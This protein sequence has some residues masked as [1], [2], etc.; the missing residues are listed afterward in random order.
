MTLF[1]FE[2]VTKR[3]PDGRH[4]LTVFE[5]VSFEIDAGDFVGLWGTRRSGKSTLLRIAAGIDVPDT[6]RVL[7]DGQD[8][9][10]LSGDQRA[11]LLRTRG[12]GLVSS[13][14]RPTVSQEVIDD[15]AVAL[16]SDSYSLRQARRIA[17]EHLEQMGALK[18]AHMRTETLSIGEAMRV[19][20]AR[21]LIREPRLLLVDEPAALPSPS[22]RQE[23]Y[24]LL[25]SLGRSR[26]LAVLIASEDL[27][28]IRRARRKMTIGAGAVR[29]MDKKGEVVSFPLGRVSD[30]RSG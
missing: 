19:G 30:G 2:Q 1:A 14:W 24:G 16:L 20:L 11:E 18:C 13:A 5:D 27:G 15:V 4:E 25:A 17:R 10:G 26:D 9:T 3:I 22:E 29:S 12:I 21:A 28:V 7:F 6:G 23:L 8:L